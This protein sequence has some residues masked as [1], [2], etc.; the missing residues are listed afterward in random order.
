MKPIPLSRYFIRIVSSAFA[1]VLPLLFGLDPVWGQPRLPNVNPPKI[2][3]PGTPNLPGQNRNNNSTQQQTPKKPQRP[4]RSGQRQKKQETKRTF[5]SQYQTAGPTDV[6]RIDHPNYKT[7][8]GKFLVGDFRKGNADENTIPVIILHGY[9]QAKEQVTPLAMKLAEA[10][11]AV[12]TPD[13]RGH[14]QSISQ[15]VQDFS[16]GERPTVRTDDNYKFD[17]FIKQDYTAMATI[18]WEFWYMFLGAEHNAKHLNMR[19]LIIIGVE[20]GAAIA[21]NWAKNDWSISNVKKGH[22]ARGLVLISPEEKYCQKA[23]DAL[24]QKKPG[25]QLAFLFILGSLNGDMLTAIKKIQ[26]K[27]LGRDKEEKIPVAEQRAVLATF[28][29]EQQGSELLAIDS[30]NIPELVTNFINI[31]MKKMKPRDLEWQAIKGD[32]EH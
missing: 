16:E 27:L 26:E 8:D 6:I 13:L 14:G 24:R 29:T 5:E 3:V 15:Q 11:M 32:D 22:F 25:D 30:F 31:R 19:R 23:L 2:Q 18:D 9:G 4:S 10:G 20:F 1:V 28:Q 12:L 21:C 17:T 7:P